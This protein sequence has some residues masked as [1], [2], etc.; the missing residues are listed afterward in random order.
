V[1]EVLAEARL[2]WQLVRGLQPLLRSPLDVPGAR[3]I[4][5]ERLERRAADFLWMARHAIY[6][7]A[8]SPYRE[9]LDAAGC[10]YPDLEQLVVK[11]GVEGALQTLLRSGV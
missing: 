6:E 9:L 10:R 5:R 2:G 8:L 1:H 3:S 4:L 11:D 7:R